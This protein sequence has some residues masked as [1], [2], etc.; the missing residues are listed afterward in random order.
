MQNDAFQVEHLLRAHVAGQNVDWDYVKST[1]NEL[2]VA[3]EV[4]TRTSLAEDPMGRALL[5]AIL[6]KNPSVDV[7]DACLRTFPDALAMNVSAYFMASRC[8]DL[9]II[10]S[11]IRFCRQRQPS[12]SCPYSWIMMSH[13]SVEAAERIIREYPQGVLQQC[14]GS[15]HC[16]L[17]RALFSVE[18][19]EHCQPHYSY[20]DKLVLMLKAVEN[21]NLDEENNKFHP[22]HT[23]VSRILTQS[24]FF[25][26]GNV[27]QHIVWLLYQLRL[28]HPSLFRVVD[29]K[30]DSP[31]HVLLR[32]PCK[33]GP[34]VA[35]AKDLIVILVDAYD[36]SAS[37]CTNEG[38]LPLF[39][40]LEN[41]WPCHDVLLHVSPDS[42]QM[43]DSETGLYPFQVAACAKPYKKRAK[44]ARIT[45]D[46]ELD[47]IYSLLR[48]DPQQVQG[49]K[50][51]S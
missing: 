47:V 19:F 6:T 22:I 51:A 40:G 39:L 13:V 10:R 36:Q 16:L 46:S 3:T 49:F 5:I 32:A 20:W 18:D 28:R 27:A 33:A 1:L 26:N 8:H 15:K 43:R 48:E 11:L 17:D 38:R 35:Y 42:L 9:N 50:Q 14:N 12:D 24:T 2:P 25:K 4:S 29:G 30:G 37:I 44:R 31:L 34:G 7:V 21:E 45:G 41:G 23:L